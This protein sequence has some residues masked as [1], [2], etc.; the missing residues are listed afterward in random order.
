MKLTRLSVLQV[1]GVL[2]GASSVLAWPDWTPQAIIDV[3]DNAAKRSVI[4]QFILDTQHPWV[5][6]NQQRL[7]NLPNAQAFLCTAGE[8]DKGS[9][10]LGQYGLEVPPDIFDYLEIINGRAG[11]SRPGWRNALARLREMKRC[12]TALARVKTFHIDIYIHDS[13]YS[14]WHLRI[15]EPAKPYAELLQLFGDVFEAMTSLESL[16]WGIR[17]QQTL[18][19][20]EYFQ[21]RGL[22]L[23]SVKRLDLGDLSHYMVGICPNLEHLNNFIGNEWWPR[24]P[25]SP[26]PPLMLVRSTASAKKL[27]SLVLRASYNGWTPSLAAGNFVLPQ[28]FSFPFADYDRAI[29]GCAAAH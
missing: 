10:E 27:K 1:L 22:A 14:P 6:Q 7:E 24:V 5:I 13:Q 20:E 26:D 8:L 9:S 4:P 21:D 25:D 15:R 3:F 29:A 28:T 17:A 12:P 18:W 23:P 2:L 19:F 11:V 16:R